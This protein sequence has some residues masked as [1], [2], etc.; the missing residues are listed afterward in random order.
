MF[1]NIDDDFEKGDGDVSS[2]YDFFNSHTLFQR[3]DSITSNY[4]DGGVD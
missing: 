3:E 1:K 4:I 2:V